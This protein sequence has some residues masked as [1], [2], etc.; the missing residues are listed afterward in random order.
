MFDFQN[1]MVLVADAKTEISIS[2]ASHQSQL[3]IPSRLPNSC[4][5]EEVTEA[6]PDS[7]AETGGTRQCQFVRDWKA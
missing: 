1:N 4:K 7:Y 6:V 5:P 2:A 3:V